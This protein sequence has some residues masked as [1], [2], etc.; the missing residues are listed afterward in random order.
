[1]FSKWI[2]TNQCMYQFLNEVLFFISNKTITLWSIQIF[3][4]GN[5][6]NMDK[7]AL[8]SFRFLTFQVIFTN[9]NLSISVVKCERRLEKKSAKLFICQDCDCQRHEKGNWSVSAALLT[10]SIWSLSLFLSLLDS[11]FSKVNKM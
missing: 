10:I 6:C 1:M 9:N 3:I 7:N 2:I 4:Y 8:F 11:K 5:Q